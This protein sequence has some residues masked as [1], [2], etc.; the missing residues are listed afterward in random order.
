MATL[1]WLDPRRDLRPVLLA[2]ALSLL[3]PFGVGA[4][5]P[6]PSP[7][8][9]DESSGGFVQG[10]FSSIFE[11][12]AGDG[13][14]GRPHVGPFYPW[15]AVVSSGAR[16]GP[17][18]MFWQRD[19]AGTGLDLQAAGSYSVRE[20]GYYA[21]RFGLLPHRDSGPVRFSTSDRLYPLKEVERLSG[22]ES[23]FDLY[24]SYSHRD[25]P[26]EDFYGVGIGAAEADRSDFALRDH[27]VE[28]VTAYHF[29]PR[30]G[31]MARAGVLD[32]SLGPGRDDS[33]ADVS[34]RFDERAAPGS[35]VSPRQ[36]VF[37]TGLMADLRD[38]PG[39]PH[40]GAL[41]TAAVSRFEDRRGGP[42][43]FTR[44]AADLRLYLPLGS[45]RHV[46]ATRA[47]GS[48]DQPDGGGRVPFYL[49]SSL[50]GSH[51]LRGYPSFRFRDEALVAVSAEYRFEIIPRL[52][53]AAFYDAGQVAPDV[54]D[55]RL[56]DLR[57]GW[58]GGVRLK[59]RRKVIVRFDVA[60]SR[61]A[62][63]YLVK[64]NSSF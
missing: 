45:K 62:T 59:S 23:R 50:G 56:S 1:G 31:V 30:V 24:L 28:L 37:T 61:E 38:E 58:G 55:F 13:E 10:K 20:Y 52:E 22:V 15:I 3:S 47:L 39:N 48:L 6:P 46:I 42:F 51:V 32:T 57:T 60:R 44:A 11:E 64:L 4:A 12:D 5:E 9:E 29:S 36:V 17:I 14:G 53:L 18:L 40:S 43:E 21:V 54:S 26:E 19:L 25:Y 2:A 34:A 35:A 41:L 63:R 49:Q 8:D 7:A 27:L 33:L 16:P